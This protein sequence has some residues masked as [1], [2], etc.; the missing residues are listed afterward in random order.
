MTDAE[1]MALLAHFDRVR[2]NEQATRGNPGPSALLARTELLLTWRGSS[3]YHQAA[4]QISRAYHAALSYTLTGPAW[5]KTLAHFDGRCAYCDRPYQ[6]FVFEHFR[7]HIMGGGFTAD[8]ILPAC[9]CC[10]LS[11]RDR[12]VYEWAIDG[13]GRAL[14]VKPE[15]LTKIDNWLSSCRGQ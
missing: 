13:R 9:A 5:V 4:L 1:F 2:E 14:G 6:A 12:D 15:A 7:P 8:N 11:R 10:N 3:Y